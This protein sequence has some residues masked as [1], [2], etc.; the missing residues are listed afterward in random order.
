M[1]IK[2]KILKWVD[3]F[4]RLEAAGLDISDR[5]VKYL[6]FRQD[7]K[8]GF[9]FFG[10][11][12]VPEGVIEK[13]EIKQ[14]E[15]LI[16]VF[17]KFLQREGRHLRSSFVVA[18]LPE[19]K[20]F[21]RLIQLPKMKKEEVANA[22]R[23]EIEANIPLPA[24]DLLYDYEIIEPV[25]GDFDHFDI[26]I[27]AF[28][29]D[30]VDS[31]VRALKQSGF[32]PL[33]LEVESQAIVR[34][35]IPQL[36]EY[37]ARIIVEMGRTRTS[38]ILFAGGAIVFTT[39]LELGG[40]TFEENIAKVLSVSPAE[41]LNI[42]RDTGLN[43]KAYDGKI[44]M[45]LEPALSVLADEVKKAIDYYQDRVKHAHGASPEINEVLL[46]GGDANLFGLDT[47]FASILKIP[48]RRAD[49]FA[50]IRGRFNYLI[51]PF[52]QNQALAFTT[53]VGL[54]MRGIR[55]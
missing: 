9:D 29:R 21:F 28:P 10:E 26:M 11:F 12:D 18:S 20:S 24:E 45:A 23:W 34:A 55:D 14:E 53:A 37:S 54:A 8:L 41:A 44:F 42:K 52:P 4:I 50:A 43:R 32:N 1:A 36:R 46:T 39:T 48:V 7:T 51:P 16:K 15:E 13:G 6:K 22:I 33:A 35:V 38:L 5:S 40:L 19:E 3:S 25:G 31:Y 30:I 17:Q 2:E 27:T 49:P 47:Y